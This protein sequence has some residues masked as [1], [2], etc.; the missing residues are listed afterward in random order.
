MAAAAS[1]RID[2]RKVVDGPMEVPSDGKVMIRPVR[3]ASALL[4]ISP[5]RPVMDTDQFVDAI[6]ATNNVSTVASILCVL[7]TY[8]LRLQPTTYRVLLS[9][10]IAFGLSTLLL[11]MTTIF[12]PSKYQYFGEAV[13]IHVVAFSPLAVVLIAIL[14]GI[15]RVTRVGLWSTVVLACVIVDWAGISAI[16]WALGS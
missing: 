15:K 5:R 10:G 7:P 8:F 11:A 16:L 1:A 13:I 4:T 14:A 3:M 9:L 12:W 2:M 6:I